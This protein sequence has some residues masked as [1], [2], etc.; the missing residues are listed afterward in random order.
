MLNEMKGEIYFFGIRYFCVMKVKIDV[1]H[2]A[3][4]SRF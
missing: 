2:D 3:M 1:I 4:G